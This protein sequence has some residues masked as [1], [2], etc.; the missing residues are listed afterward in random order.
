MWNPCVVGLWGEGSE[1]RQFLFLLEHKELTFAGFY[2]FPF[3]FYNIKTG[4]GFFP[5][6][7]TCNLIFLF[8]PFLLGRRSPCLRFYLLP[9]SVN[10]ARGSLRSLGREQGPAP[11]RKSKL[12]W[13][14]WAGAAALATPPRQ[15][16]P[17]LQGISSRLHRDEYAKE[18]E[19]IISSQLNFLMLWILFLAKTNNRHLKKKWSLY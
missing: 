4:V 3:F 18:I 19:A 10:A 8:P 16:I 11:C 12:S 6:N 7:D 15:K 9:P 5:A 2:L 1:D 13:F 14:E 17:A